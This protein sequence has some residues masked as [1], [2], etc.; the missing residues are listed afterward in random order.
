MS[1]HHVSSVAAP[2]GRHRYCRDPGEETAL[3]LAEATAR[4]LYRAHT[5]P[6]LSPDDLLSEAYI[7]ALKAHRT[8]QEGKGA[9][10]KTRVITHVRWAIQECY[11]RSD[12][13]TR[14]DR[15]KE[16]ALD[17]ALETVTD[18]DER[19]RLEATRLPY[20]YGPIALSEILGE[21]DEPIAEEVV[22]ALSTMDDQ[23]ALLNRVTIR[24]LLALLTPRQ[25]AVVIL[26]YWEERTLV[27]ISAQLE[28]STARV[29]QILEDV[30]VRLR[31]A[32]LD[33]ELVPQAWAEPLGCWHA[34]TDDELELWRE[35][36][37]PVREIAVRYGVTRLTAHKRL[38]NIRRARRKALEDAK[39]AAPSLQGDESG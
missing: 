8:W 22:A 19:R 5:D 35:R 13:L 4:R 26:L 38:Y 33:G 29:H 6:I 20:R 2:P 36:G 1:S 34:V 15:Q 23:D 7:A 11:R 21:D 12:W 27:E 9:S 14:G 25:R 28:V 24:P 16:K 17:R 39:K 37:D 3:R 30:Y 31:P 18:P 32:L 10:H